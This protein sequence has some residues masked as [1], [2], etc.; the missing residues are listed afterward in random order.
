MPQTRGDRMG[1]GIALALALCAGLTLVHRAR[2]RAHRS[3]PV[4]SVVR[5]E[6]VAPPQ[7]WALDASRWWHLHVAAVGQGPRLA[8][9]NAALQAQVQAL[10][11][12]NKALL[13]AQAENASLRQQLGYQKRSPLPLLP[14]EVI[15]LKPTAQ[16][17][18]L[19][20]DRGS[21]S[22]V[23]LSS[24]VLSARGALIGQVVDV[25]PHSCNVLMLTDTNSAAGAEVVR[26]G[27]SAGQDGRRIGICRGDPLGR[28]TLTVARLDADVKPGDSVVTSGLGAVFP[29]GLPIGTVI[30]V[31]T[32]RARAVRQ[33]LL[34]P[35]A[36]FDHLQQ[37]FLVQ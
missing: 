28:L 25:S 2:L 15:A 31:R 20:L 36:D 29:P 21:G 23:R 16:A 17:D 19:T 34:R 27:T 13:A 1:R 4:V 11:A 32:D 5:D 37:A 18:T 22:G 26:P 10:E 9:E 3:D 6:L 35:A 12:Q 7:L 14:A 8:R 30:S 33:A 24:V